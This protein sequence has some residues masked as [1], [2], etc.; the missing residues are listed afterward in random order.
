[1]SL[2]VAGQPFSL[3][4]VAQRADLAQDL[5]DHLRDVFRDG[6]GG[7]EAGG[8]D[9]HEMNRLRNTGIPGDDEVGDAVMT[10]GN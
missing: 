10:C 3:P 5:R 8:L 7:G 9:A 4:A 2:A 6:R 1:M